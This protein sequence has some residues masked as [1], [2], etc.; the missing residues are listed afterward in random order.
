MF[1]CK[2]KHLVYYNFAYKVGPTYLTDRDEIF[3]YSE[4]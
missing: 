4:K 2:S 1:K 3:L